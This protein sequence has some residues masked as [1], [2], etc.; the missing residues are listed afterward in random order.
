MI[1]TYTSPYSASWIADLILFIVGIPFAVGDLY[2]AHRDF[3]CVWIPISNAHINF[4]L[5]RWLLAD[6]GVLI[7]LLVLLLI[8]G[9]VMCCCPIGCEC[10]WWFRNILGFLF[11]IWRLAWLIVGAVM[12]WGFLYKKNYCGVAVSRFMWANLIV[13]FIH[14][15]F[16][17]ILPCFCQPAAAA[18]GGAYRGSGVGYR[19]S[20]VGYR[21]SG[22]GVMVPTP[23]PM[24]PATYRTSTVL[25]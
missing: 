3:T 14:S 15:F 23:I 16:Y 7:A 18:V 11:A 17:F 21:G 24:M 8:F 13:G 20:G 22:V 25:Y 4:P 19:G 2:Y 5:R 10:L 9:I 1:G 12:F 6:G